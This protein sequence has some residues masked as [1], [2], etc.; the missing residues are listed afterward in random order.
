MNGKSI[1]AR[2]YIGILYASYDL[3]GTMKPV[4][5]GYMIDGG[6][7][8]GIGNRKMERIRNDYNTWEQRDDYIYANTEKDIW[9]Y[10]ESKYDCP[11]CCGW[12]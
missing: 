5:Y 10:V 12:F 3:G 4:A 6:T 1:N 8:C 7:T 11:I 9:D 2:V